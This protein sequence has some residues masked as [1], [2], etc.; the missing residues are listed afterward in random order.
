MTRPGRQSLSEGVDYK[1]KAEG[2]ENEQTHHKLLTSRLDG[3]GTS[4]ANGRRGGV[5]SRA[6][7]ATSVLVHMACVC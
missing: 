2:P 5:K 7:V 3:D 4:R 1:K 6:P